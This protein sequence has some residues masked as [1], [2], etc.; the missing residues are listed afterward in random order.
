MNKFNKEDSPRTNYGAM[1]EEE[2]GVS[3]SAQTIEDVVIRFILW[4]KEVD[5]DTLNINEKDS[6]ENIAK[7]ICRQFL[8]TL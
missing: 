3:K 6:D 7:H 1:Y 4:L 2:N 5:E 8:K